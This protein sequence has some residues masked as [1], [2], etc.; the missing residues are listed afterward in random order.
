MSATKT[1]SILETLELDAATI[2]SLPEQALS[3]LIGFLE[4]GSRRRRGDR[5]VARI[6]DREPFAVDTTA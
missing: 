2:D 3:E 5:E 4:D 6:V 1:A